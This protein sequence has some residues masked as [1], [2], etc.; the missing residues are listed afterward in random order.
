MDP[1][2]RP[3]TPPEWLDW[4]HGKLTR[5]WAAGQRFTNYYEGNHELMRF[6]QAQYSN[7][8]GEIFNKWADNFCGLVVDSANE[9]MR[10]EGFRMTDDPSADRDAQEIWQRNHM[11]AD[12][13]AA[14]LGAMVTGASFAVVWADSDGRPTITAESSENIAVQFKAGSKRD[15]EV[16]AK[17]TTDDWG[18]QTATLWTDTKVYT[19]DNVKGEWVNPKV[20]RNPLGTNPVIPLINRNRLAAPNLWH[21]YSDLHDIIPIQDAINKTVQDA[22]VASEYAAFPQRYV[23]GMEITEDENGNPV[24]P[25]QVAVDKLLQAEDPDTRFGSFEAANL[26]NYCVLIDK[27]VANMAAKAKL[28]FHYFLSGGMIPSGDAIASAE[29]GLISKTRERM[30]HFGEGWER[31]MRLAFK[32]LGDPRQDAFQ[33]ETIWADPEIRTE[34]QHIDALIK[35][36]ALGIP[37]QALWEKAGYTPPQIQRFNRMLAEQEELLHRYPAML[38]PSKGGVDLAGLAQ[39]APQGNSGN[40]NRKL[41]EAGGSVATATKAAGSSSTRPRSA[42]AKNRRPKNKPA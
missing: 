20:G 5:N 21:P 25:F 23:T 28:P 9:R 35:Q 3:T 1:F 40:V 24:A 11:D 2:N 30:L 37:R 19:F 29:A 26:A 33:A 17:F 7:A 32:V 38:G 18:R 15:I 14:H 4:L 31:A 27:L 16:S 41:A 39:K 6:A 22:I 10:V 36:S 13:N 8:F 34:A 42:P 12:S